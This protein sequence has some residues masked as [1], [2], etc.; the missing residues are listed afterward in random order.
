MLVGREYQLVC[1]AVGSKPPPV[2]TWF[3]NRK[4]VDQSKFV[5]SIAR[6]CGSVVENTPINGNLEVIGLNPAEFFLSTLFSTLAQ[7]LKEKHI[8]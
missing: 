2:F 8:Y 6:S 1:Q 5:V 7:V 4:I 3:K